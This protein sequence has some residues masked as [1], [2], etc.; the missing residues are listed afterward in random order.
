[1]VQLLAARR[2]GLSLAA[3]A[4]AVVAPIVLVLPALGLAWVAV[5]G[6]ESPLLRVITGAALMAAT[7]AGLWI[8]LRTSRRFARLL[9]D[10]PL[11]SASSRR[12]S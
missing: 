3:Q 12:D 10:L 6:L 9:P 4:H 7:F 11:F 5:D 2:F 1:M 8:L